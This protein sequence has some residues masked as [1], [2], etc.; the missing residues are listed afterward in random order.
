MS[1]LILLFFAA[2]FWG[3][4]LPGVQLTGIH[5]FGARLLLPVAWCAALW[6][7]RDEAR[8]RAVIKN[9]YFYFALVWLVWAGISLFWVQDLGIAA[10][11]LLHLIFG[12]SIPLLILFLTP[13]QR[14]LLPL[15]WVGTAVIIIFLGAVQLARVTQF[16]PKYHWLT[17]VYGNENDVS[18]FI[19]LSLPL[20]LGYGLRRGDGWL[21][22][23][24]LRIIAVLAALVGVSL[25]LLTTARLNFIALAMLVIILP[26]IFLRH[27]NK[28]KKKLLPY[29]KEALTVMVL[30]ALLGISLFT[31]PGV[32][33]RL[34]GQLASIPAEI[35]GALSG[36]MASGAR[37]RLTVL[38]L[39]LVRDTRGLGVGPGNF[40]PHLTK[41]L[42][43]GT[44]NP[45][46]WW[47]ELL[48]EYG[49]PV[50]LGYCA[51]F[52]YLIIAI[53][54]RW[55]RDGH[56]AAGAVLASLLVFPVLAIGPSR[57]I[58]YPP[59]WLLLAAAVALTSGQ[60]STVQ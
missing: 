14:E 53:Y 18:M 5:L 49:A 27:S 22:S 35:K 7:L 47:V 54:R 34:K 19:T 4:S 21:W 15:I 51:L 42:Q 3:A 13:K 16:P 33:T 6:L 52:I 8:R 31:A 36:D 58:W 60:K 59:H 38:G 17:A 23:K 30:L 1:I 46:N 26:I 44:L 32:N 24:P 41:Y 40:E 10:Q 43:R 20:L 29:T 12:L 50:F 25:I 28:G 45:H 48:A 57:L 9:P 11:H 2:S 56:W 37:A 55:R 39:N